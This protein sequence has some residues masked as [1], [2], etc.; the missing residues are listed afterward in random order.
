MAGIQRLSGETEKEYWE[1]V[2]SI[3]DSLDCL[4][5][6]NG[7]VIA[8]Y[9]PKYR[10]VPYAADVLTGIL[11]NTQDVEEAKAEY[12]REKYAVAY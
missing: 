3:V 8:S 4:D 7:Q 6:R 12:F 11:E 5:R 1:R 9:P 2:N 10:V